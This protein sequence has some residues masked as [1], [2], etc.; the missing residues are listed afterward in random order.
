MA[1]MSN[2]QSV[3][4]LQD[5]PEAERRTRMIKYTVAMGIR[6]ACIGVCF[7]VSGWWLLLPAI[8]A[9][10]LPYIAVVLATSVTSNKARTAPLRP[11]TVS[12][13]RDK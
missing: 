9:I 13:A 7:F 6:L 8:G 4:S 3:T 2:P 10:L 11:G 12:V 1:S 5:S